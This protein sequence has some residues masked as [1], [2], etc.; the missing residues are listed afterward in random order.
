MTPP[1]PRASHVKDSASSARPSM[2]RLLGVSK[3]FQE[4]Q[5]SRVIFNQLDGT[6]GEG[7]IVALLGRSGCGKSTLLNLIAGLDAPDKGKIFVDGNEITG[8]TDE[9]RSLFRRHAIGFVFQFFNLI[10]TLKVEEN[11][12]LP[13]ELKRR[14]GPEDHRAAL[15]LLGEV[16]LEDRAESFP[17]VLSGG[18]QQ[19]V[20]IARAL[21]HDPA[22][23]L[24]DEPTGNLDLETGRQVLELLFR[25]TRQ[26]R[27]TML[28]VTHSPEVAAVADRVF[29]LRDGHL[30]P[31]ELADET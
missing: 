24:A 2:V 18:E 26:R 13:I 12:L 10:P 14:I 27:R 6:F 25:M 7:E 3:A 21:V 4:G 30:E 29:S 23:I 1:G 15:T 9:Q 16:G 28:L 11:L 5:N 17:D 8:M 20:A 31:R 19:R 22:L